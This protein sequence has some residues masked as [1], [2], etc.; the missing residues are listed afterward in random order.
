MVRNGFREI[1]STTIFATAL[2][3]RMSLVHQH[4]RGVDFTVGMWEVDLSFC[5]LHV[6]MITSVIVAMVVMSMTAASIVRMHALW[7]GILNTSL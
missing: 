4:V 1:E 3:G 7:V 5:F 2:T 6:L